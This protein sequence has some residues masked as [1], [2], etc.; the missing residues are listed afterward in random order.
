MK[1][2]GGRPRKYNTPEELQ[3]A[4]EEFFEWCEETGRTPL[5]GELAYFLG[6]A[7]RQSLRDYD[8]PEKF[9]EFSCIIR[10]AKLK[11]ENELN[12]KALNGDVNPQIAKLNL[13]TNY[14]YNE[15]KEIDW[16]GSQIIYL[17]KQDE[18]L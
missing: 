12:Q 2:P 16:K 10:R 3:S 1:H 4:I 18:N 13:A 5:Q 14:G 17:D 7:S 11:C 9:P 15:K 6:F 8:D